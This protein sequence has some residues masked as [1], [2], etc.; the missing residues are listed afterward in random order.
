[1]AGDAFPPDDPVA[2]W[3]L[4]LILTLHDLLIVLDRLDRSL[5]TA[6]AHENLYN[7]RL[8]ASHLWEAGTFLRNSTRFPEITEFVEALPETTRQQY[9]TISAATDPQGAGFA[10]EL[11]RLRHHFFHY[12]KLI[13]NGAEYEELTRALAAHTRDVSTLPIRGP[14][15]DFRSPLADDIATELTLASDPRPFLEQLSRTTVAC[16]EFIYAALQE[17]VA[18][19]SKKFDVF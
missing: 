7:A 19:G 3:M 13:P 11:K 6:P 16:T 10:Q 12:A 5:D 2:R 18:S 4:V 17:F 9:A 8:A 14:L 1:V 15:R